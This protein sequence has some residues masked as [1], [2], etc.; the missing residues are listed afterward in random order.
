M[1]TFTVT[2]TLDENDANPTEANPGGAGLSLREALVLANDNPGADTIEFA[3]G[4]GEA[5]E[6][7]GTITLTNGQ[8]VGG[9]SVTILGDADGDG[10][11]VVLDGDNAS[12]VLNFSS[13][14]S[15][16]R[17]EDLTIQNGN[18]ARYGGGIYVGGSTLTGTNITVTG[19]HILLKCE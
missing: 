7:G 19:N 18:I 16:F 14:G 15:T 2:T 6:N 8:L 1:A 17:I 12:R 3:A 13:I 10:N 4:A 5:F 11:G 9:E